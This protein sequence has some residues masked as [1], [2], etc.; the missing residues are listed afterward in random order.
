MAWHRYLRRSR[1]SALRCHTEIVL[2]QAYVRRRVGF[3]ERDGV[4]A[5]LHVHAAVDLRTHSDTQ[6]GA[7]LAYQVGRLTEGTGNATIF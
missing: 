4:A 7:L 5:E 2:A 3:R 1:K 6:T